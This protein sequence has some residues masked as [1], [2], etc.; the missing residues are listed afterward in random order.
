MLRRLLSLVSLGIVLVG[1]TPTHF[2]HYHRT[3]IGIDS[4][5]AMDGNGGHL[6]VGYDRRLIAVVPDAAGTRPTGQTQPGGAGTPQPGTGTQAKDA[7]STIFCT[8][9]D[10]SALGVGRFHE[11]LATGSVATAYARAL[12]DDPTGGLFSCF[13][14][15][16]TTTGGREGKGTP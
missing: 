15:S 9:L 11:T 1:C 6:T 12:R 13:V 16:G 2:I 14:P 10:A 5:A 3:V 7:M 8:Q 4:S